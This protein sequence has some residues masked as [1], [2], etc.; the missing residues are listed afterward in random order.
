[1]Y[2]VAAN[3]APAD[4]WNVAVVDDPTYAV[5]DSD[6]STLAGALAAGANGAVSV[7][8]G[9]ILWSVAAGDY[10]LDFNVAGERVTGTMSGAADP[11]TLTISVRAV[12][13]VS[14]DLPAG[15]AVSLWLP[16]VVG[17]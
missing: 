12:N 10:P 16:V 17:V 11:Q 1:V 6:S 4:P 2:A 3:T 13:G 9:G 14:K 5:V 7:N 8:V 15:A